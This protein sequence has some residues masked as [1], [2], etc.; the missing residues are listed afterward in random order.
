MLTTRLVSVRAARPTGGRSIASGASLLV[1]C[2]F[3]VLLVA[4]CGP[5]G[6]PVPIVGDAGLRRDIVAGTD[7]TTPEVASAD[8]SG[9]VTSD[10]ATEALDPCAASPAGVGCPCTQSKDCVDTA[11]CVEGAEKAS[12]CADAWA[13]A[14]RPCRADADC[15]L[16]GLPDALQGVC[17]SLGNAGS[18]CMPMQERRVRGWIRMRRAVRG[19]QGL[20]AGVGRV[21]VQ[22]PR[23]AGG[24]LH[25][26]LPGQR[27]RHVSRR[28]DLPCG[29]SL[30]VRGHGGR[31]RG[32]R[33]R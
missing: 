5:A 32:V 8:V 6:D 3:P 21:H 4:G 19:R 12:L 17:A 20:F 13:T 24:C 16:D 26:L 31:A 7:A 11:V 14:C 2:V 25:G 33:R 18:F 10:V 28:R 23:Q 1:L 22:R 27:T 29:R 30:A 9:E 15:R